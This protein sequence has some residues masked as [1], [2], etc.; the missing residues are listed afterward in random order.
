MSKH[1]HIVLV[2]DD[3]PTTLLNIKQLLAGEP[4]ELMTVTNAK[5]ALELTSRILPDLILLDVVMPQMDGFAVCKILREREGAANIPILLLTAL[6][7]PESRLKGLEHG[8]DD[9]ISKPFDAVELKARVRTILRLDRARRINAVRDRFNWVLETVQTGFVIT[10]RR[11]RILYANPTGRQILELTSDETSLTFLEAALQ[12]CTLRPEHLWTTW[13]APLPAGS[14][15]KRLLIRPQSSFAPAQWLEVEVLQQE[16]DPDQQRVIQ[17]RDITEAMQS[18]QNVWTFHRFISH[19]LR[20]PINTLL[21]G[22]EMLHESLEMFETEEIQ[23]IVDMGY[24]SLLRLKNEVSDIEQFVGVSRDVDTNAPAHCRDLPGLVKEANKLLELE[25]VQVE[26]PAELADRQLLLSLPAL[27]LI[28]AELM[29]NAAKFHPRH[30]PALQLEMVA[31]DDTHVRLRLLDDGVR[32]PSAL[33]EQAWQP[34]FQAEG[35]FTGEVDGMGLGLPMVAALVWR[36][37][38]DCRMLNRPD[39]PGIIIELD[40]PTHPQA[41]AASTAP[42]HVTSPTH[43]T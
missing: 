7:D 2:V 27:T 16:K 36:A 4:Y 3:D 25:S 35:R 19:K 28:L 31:L 38:G 17:L 32:L 43:Q 39:Q 23:Y 40:I 22:V 6:D 5:R 33:L 24:E 1:Q 29:D 30:Q 9:F 15:E 34:Y 12:H 11:D 13:P 10:D 18:Q 37:G 21:T 42:A 26:C 8:A 20:S 14:R 41:L